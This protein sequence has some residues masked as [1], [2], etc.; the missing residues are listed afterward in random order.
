MSDAYNLL[1]VWYE[2]QLLATEASPKEYGEDYA[3]EMWGKA[4]ESRAYDVQC[5]VV[6]TRKDSTESKKALERLLYLIDSAEESG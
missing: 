6:A 4:L 5:R 2:D 3:L 1:A